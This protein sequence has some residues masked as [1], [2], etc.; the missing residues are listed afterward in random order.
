MSR[1][2]WLCTVSTHS[3]QELRNKPA[4]RLWSGIDSGNSTCRLDT[5]M[6]DMMRD[7]FEFDFTDGVKRRPRDLVTWNEGGLRHRVAALATYFLVPQDS[8]IIA[9]NAANRRKEKSFNSIYPLRTFHPPAIV[10][11]SAQGDH[12]CSLPMSSIV[13]AEWTL[14][15]PSALQEQATQWRHATHVQ[16]PGES[17][18]PKLARKRQDA[19]VWTC[20]EAASVWSGRAGP[21]ALVVRGE[22]EVEMDPDQ[23]RGI[24]Q[25]PCRGRGDSAADSRAG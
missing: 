21:G 9:S 15:R 24:K 20:R 6:P 8:R 23:A 22:E 12:F 5:K 19:G 11:T 2:M 25:W 10:P 18:G 17:F 7:R 3:H 1:Y 4:G 14:A 16:R 13:L